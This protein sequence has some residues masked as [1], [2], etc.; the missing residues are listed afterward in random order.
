LVRASNGGAFGN[1]A[2]GFP[3]SVLQRLQENWG[4]YTKGRNKPTGVVEIGTALTTIKTTRK[5]AL[6]QLAD[7]KVKADASDKRPSGKRQPATIAFY[8][9]V[10]AIAFTAVEELIAATDVLN[11]FELKWFP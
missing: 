5:G 10:A 11:K 7:V 4:S 1:A 3:V 6:D 2:T 9:M 8:K